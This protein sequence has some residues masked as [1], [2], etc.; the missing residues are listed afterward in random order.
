MAAAQCGTFAVHSPGFCFGPILDI[1]YASR[2]PIFSPPPE[3]VLFA[4]GSVKVHDVAKCLPAQF[5]SWRTY[6]LTS[7]HAPHAVTGWFAAHESVD[8]RAELDKILRVAGSPYEDDFGSRANNAITRKASVLL[9]NRY[10]WM[11]PRDNVTAEFPDAW[12]TLKENPDPYAESAGYWNC[13]GLVDYAHAAEQAQVWSWSVPEQRQSTDNAV[14]MHVPFEEYMWARIGFDDEYTLARSF[15]YFQI[16]TDFYHTAFPGETKP[17]RKY[18]T[19]LERFERRVREGDDYSGLDEFNEYALERYTLYHEHKMMWP[20]PHEAELLGPYPKRLHLF[21]LEDLEF[22]GERNV[23]R[24]HHVLPST[25]SPEELKQWLEDNPPAVFSPHFE[26]EIVDLLNEMALAFLERIIPSYVPNTWFLTKV[27]RDHERVNSF[28][29]HVHRYLTIHLASQS[30][31]EKYLPRVRTFFKETTLGVEPKDMAVTGLLYA[32]IHLI[33]TIITDCDY[34]AIGLHQKRDKGERPIIVPATIRQV[35]EDN[36]DVAEL[37]FHS[38]VLW[39]G[40][41]ADIKV[42]AAGAYA[43]MRYTYSTFHSGF[44]VRN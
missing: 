1:H 25:V 26:E 23:P 44:L 21:T 39:Q 3:P 24:R 20:V 17:I 29:Y 4:S 8:A 16:H 31:F 32:T 19:E 13:M 27:L 12:T 5:G 15:L 30:Y 28:Q 11:R 41:S 9:V 10:D 18:E 35:M 37:V 33:W 36:Y 7:I 14:W 38:R 40:R 2:D 6:P 22:F 42:M 43:N 34:W